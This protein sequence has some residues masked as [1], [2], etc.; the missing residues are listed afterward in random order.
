MLRFGA[1]AL[2]L[3]A[4]A[5]AG[6]ATAG[7]WRTD[8]ERRPVEE[9]LSVGNVDFDNPAQ[10][11]ILYRKLQYAAMRVCASDKPQVPGVAEDDATCAR[12]VLA[13]TVRRVGKP[14]LTQYAAQMN[15]SADR[16]ALNGR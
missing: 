10:V 8:S 13:D 4:T 15:N 6:A 7:D 12:D 2:I 11:K 14:Q 1:L 5:F 3:S 9:T 16:L